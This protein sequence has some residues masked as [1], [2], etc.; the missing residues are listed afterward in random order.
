MKHKFGH[1]YFLAA[2][3]TKTYKKSSIESHLYVYHTPNEAKKA[4][5]KRKLVDSSGQKTIAIRRKLSDAE[6]TELLNVKTELLAD[7][8]LSF[9][10]FDSQAWKN[11]EETLWRLSNNS[12]ED[13]GRVPSSSGNSID[14]C[15]F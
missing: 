6:R 2:G 13:F 7:Q 9:R 15:Y 4:G 10:C 1:P 3:N 12:L 14:V 8:G 11:Y 5:K